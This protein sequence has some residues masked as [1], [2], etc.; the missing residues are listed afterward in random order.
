MGVDGTPRGWV[1]AVWEGTRLRL[2]YRT[3]PAELFEAA[4]QPS[5]LA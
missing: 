5:V 3:D 4:G 1:G 2:L